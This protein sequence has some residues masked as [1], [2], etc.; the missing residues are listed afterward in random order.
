MGGQA[1][2]LGPRKKKKNWKAYLVVRG[3]YFLRLAD[4][5]TFVR[6][7]LENA[8]HHPHRPEN[9]IRADFIT[10]DVCWS[11]LTNRSINAYLGCKICK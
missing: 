3:R 4:L 9:K 6:V 8:W 11:V 5:F 10:K 1:I 7:P 2:G